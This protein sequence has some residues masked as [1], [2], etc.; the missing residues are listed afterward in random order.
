VV[1]SESTQSGAIEEI[2]EEVKRRATTLASISAKI[3][4]LEDTFSLK[5]QRF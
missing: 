4:P 3:G 5:K 1:D 2:Q